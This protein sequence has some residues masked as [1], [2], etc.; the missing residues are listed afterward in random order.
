MAYALLTF[1]LIFIFFA[2]DKTKLLRLVLRKV[3]S[4]HFVWRA[5]GS[6]MWVGGVCVVCIDVYHFYPLPIWYKSI[7]FNEAYCTVFFDTSV[8]P[9]NRWSTFCFSSRHHISDRRKDATNQAEEKR[10]RNKKAIRSSE[11]GKPD[12]FQQKRRRKKWEMIAAAT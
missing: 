6:G 7:R 3:F 2:K 5:S 12:I 9:L 8:A 1:R 10:T 11:S 4:V